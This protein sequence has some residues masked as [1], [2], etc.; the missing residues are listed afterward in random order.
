MSDDGQN[1]I[2]VIALL[3]NP[4]SPAYARAR[5]AGPTPALGFG[6]M[7]VALYGRARAGWALVEQP[8]READRAATSLRI[9]RS[10]MGWSSDALHVDVDERTTMGGALRGRIRVQ[11]EALPSVCFALDEA[12]RHL[13]WP[14]APLARIEVDLPSPG[15]RFRG[16]G[17]HDANAGTVPLEEDFL[18][19]TWAR[20]RGRAGAWLHYA[21]QDLSGH[22]RSTTLCVTASGGL[23]ALGAA[24]ATQLPRTLWGVERSVP[25]EA[26]SGARLVRTLEDGPFYA[27][28]LVETHVG[29]ERLLAMHESLRADRLRRGWVQF[30]AR[31]RMRRAP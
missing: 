24:P 6:S 30:L 13:W 29:G 12:D 8:V 3:G 21:R 25:S 27:R 9:G 31:F 26:P 17:Y 4:F 1:A 19:W 20:A 7:H 22:A 23:E 28:S 2:V 16:H 10:L 11:P 5:R 18:G 14:V 15:V